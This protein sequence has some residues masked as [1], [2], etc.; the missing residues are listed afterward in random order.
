MK[1]LSNDTPV[2][3][4]RDVRE[5]RGA[6]GLV[7]RW[8]STLQTS[9]PVAGPLLSSVGLVLLLSA[10]GGG[11]GGT[12]AA[13]VPAP[14]P[15]ALSNSISGAPS[16]GTTVGGAGIA[17]GAAP[18]V[19]AATAPATPAPAP[20][21]PATTAPA[22]TTP[23][24]TAPATTAPA[25]SP[26]IWYAHFTQQLCDAGDCFTQRFTAP[27]NNVYASQAA[28]L[29]GGRITTAALNT[30]ATAVISYSYSCNQTP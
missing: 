23:A 10:C 21:A 24:T 20:T 16:G 3:V 26:G 25:G 22:A 30:A 6:P 17:P 29:E 13:D 12:V 15:P 7:R 18:A 1:S 9:H 5:T 27:G 28:C 4:K 11:G 14:A 8:V 19:P 2:G